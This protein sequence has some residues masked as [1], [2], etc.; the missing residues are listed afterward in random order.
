[1]Y[2]LY[3][4]KRYA[5]LYVDD[6]ERS[7]RQF[8]RAFEGSFKVF[9]ASNA[10]D[11][12]KLFEENAK[13][14]GILITDQRMPGEQGVQLLEKARHAQPRIVRILT[15]A[16]SDLEAAI[17]AV[18]A[19]A[20][21]RY[22]HKP[23]DPPELDLTLRRAMEFFL[24][25]QERDQL[26]REK[27][28]VLHKMM[29]TDR[30]ISLGVLA[31]GIG[32][33]VRNSLVAIR[34]FLDLAPLKLQEEQLNLDDLRNPNFWVDFYQHVQS[35]VNRITSLLHTLET[36]PSYSG[37]QFTE[38]VHL[39]QIISV[40][41]DRIAPLLANKEIVFQ[42]SIPENLPELIVDG[43]KFRKLFELLL[44]DEISILPPQTKIEVSA[45]HL[46]QTEVQEESVE[47][48]IKD[49]GPGL[50]ESAVR[51]IFDPFYIATDRPQEFGLNL[52][53]C[54]FIT[55]H[56]GGKI[57]VQNN[58]SGGVVFKLLFPV[59]PKNLEESA[60][61]KHFLSKAL[62]NEVLWERMLTGV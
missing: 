37:G 43:R 6:E 7:L 2:N 18:N 34:T 36:A 58:K 59:S 30:V 5:I 51:S 26:L 50:P 40:V 27:L 31:A 20:I 13:E 46:P 56:H 24:V 29:I 22:I 32:H 39:R 38:K 60:E 45:V 47:I 19:G 11:G 23:W 16:Y 21:Y 52:M 62:L 4:Y 48:V 41:A 15:T 17:E 55:F 57:S 53:T 61:E 10:K 35:Q 25:Q 9:T 12:F 28:S 1:M 33:H 3:D 14:I 44:E 42:G 8:T 54:Y 49:N